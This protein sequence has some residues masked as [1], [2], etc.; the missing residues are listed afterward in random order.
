[1]FMKKIRC[2]SGNML[3]ILAAIFMALDHIG[4]ILFPRIIILRYIG[5]FAFPIFAMMISEGA[6]YT[7]NKLRYFLSIFCL[8]IICQI[9]NYIFNNHSLYMCILVTFSLSIFLIY[10]LEYI[11]KFLFK[12][13]KNK[14]IKIIVS[15]I[16]LTILIIS[17]YL[18][19]TIIKIDY[20]FWGI[21]TPFLA[22]LFNF[23]VFNINSKIKK[24]DN[25]YLRLLCLS[26][27]LIA[28]SIY[29]KDI[30][31]ISL[32]SILFLLMYSEKRGKLKMKYFFYF[33]FPLHLAVIYIISLII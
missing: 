22:I 21:I 8:A 20:C 16:I 2:L 26:I 30:Q 1:M 23:R 10:C 7:K 28:I 18:L 4:A 12:N 6:K 3:K 27:G 15:C 17:I 13:T 11:K 5:R 9:V 25:Y 32:F 24:L 33:F 19:T 31:Y 14:L 29:L